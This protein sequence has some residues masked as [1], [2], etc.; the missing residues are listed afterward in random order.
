MQMKTCQFVVR[1]KRRLASCLVMAV[2]SQIA[3]A[4]NHHF[5]DEPDSVYLFSYATA[6]NNNHDGLQFA[7][8]RDKITWYNIGD[9]YGFVKSDYGTWGAEKRMISPYLIQGARGLWHCVWSLNEKDNV[10][11]HAAPND[12]LTL[13]RIRTKKS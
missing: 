6:K 10:F 3:F 4:N 9:D 12:L 7:W 5:N 1:F 2:L 11:A 13:I 8:S